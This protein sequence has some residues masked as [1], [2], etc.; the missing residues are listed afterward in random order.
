MRQIRLEGQLEIV[1]AA[2]ASLGAS[3]FKFFS[4]MRG[5]KKAPWNPKGLLVIIGFGIYKCYKTHYI[6]SIAHVHNHRG[7][8][9]IG[10]T[11]W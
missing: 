5:M 10:A 4:G 9:L 11:R 2:M 1:R 6:I 8:G 3:V 7:V